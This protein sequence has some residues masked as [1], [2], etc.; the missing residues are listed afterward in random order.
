RRVR[1]AQPHGAGHDRVPRRG[2]WRHGR[3]HVPADLRHDQRGAVMP[4]GYQRRRG[5][6]SRRALV[7]LVLAVSCNE[8]WATPSES[9]VPF[10]SATILS[11]TVTPTSLTMK[12][13]DE[14]TFS[15]LVS[16]TPGQVTSYAAVWSTS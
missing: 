13:G 12:V 11:V 4:A 14:A 2:G 9:T 16:A 3:R 6:F 15:A 8:H 1:P 7:L 10:L 5:V